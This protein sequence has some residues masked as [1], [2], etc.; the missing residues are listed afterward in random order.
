[1]ISMTRAEPALPDTFTTAAARRLGVHPRDLYAWRDRGQIIE[2]SRGVFRRADA[3][4]AT[5]PDFLA[6]K[7]RAPLA[8][9]C[10]ISAAAVLD[11]T[12]E[13]PATVQ[14]AVPGGTHPPLIDHPP[15]TVFRFDEDTFKMGLS[16]IEAA[17]GERV[18]IYDG[19]RTV[20]DLMRLRHRF[21]EPVAYTALN[22]YLRQRDAR[23]SRLLDYAAALHAYG[24]VRR[25][26]DVASAQ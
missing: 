2:L 22:R 24:P 17:P 9:V 6:V 21:G 3:P 26:I 1:M 14:I 18:R 15:A 20:V 11:L 12:D 4:E 5:F 23:P 10:C 13:L 25:A 7:Y 19:A 16:H 8:V